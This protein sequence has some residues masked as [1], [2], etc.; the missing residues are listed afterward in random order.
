MVPR[1]S[2]AKANSVNTVALAKAGSDV[3][4]MPRTPYVV[5]ELAVTLPAWD[6]LYLIVFCDD[7]QVLGHFGVL[8]VGDGGSAAM[9]DYAWTLEEPHRGWKC[10]GRWDGQCGS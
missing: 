1:L 6:V 9:H 3:T 2:L 8:R 7:R 10:C 4:G 5:V